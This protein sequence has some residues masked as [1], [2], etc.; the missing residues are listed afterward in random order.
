MKGAIVE[1]EQIRAA[2]ALIGWTAADLARESGVSYPTVQRMDAT[3]GQVSGRH[4]T[5]QAI[6]KAL[7]AQG[8]QFLDAG[9]VANGP[10]V[11]T[12]VRKQ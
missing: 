6:R 10:G 3:R 8:V 5:V 12:T 9:Q 11:A 2:R 1:G 7:E 4:E